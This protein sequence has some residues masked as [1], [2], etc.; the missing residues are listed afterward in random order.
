L[1]LEDATLL[2]GFVAGDEGR[3]RELLERLLPL[4]ERGLRRRW[5]ALEASHRDIIG[6]CGVVLVQWRAELRAE[7]GDKLHLNEPIATL[8]DRLLNQEARKVRLW[9]RGAASVVDRLAEQG[10]FVDPPTPEDAVLEAENQR[11]VESV[12]ESLAPSAEQTLRAQLRHDA[13]E[14]PPLHEA[15]GCSRGAARVRL[16]RARQ[17]LTDLLRREV[18]R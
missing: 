1:L 15:L 14:G 7:R 4:L 5:P 6:A 10:E 16:T 3:T 9:Q 18:K 17:A 2:E 12:L 11:R 8:A 13:A